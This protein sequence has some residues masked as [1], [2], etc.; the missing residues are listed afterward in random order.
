MKRATAI[1]V[2]VL[3]TAALPAAQ[4]ARVRDC[5]SIITYTFS[6]A[7]TLT[8]QTGSVEIYGP[9]VCVVQDS[10]GNV[11]SMEYTSGSA[12]LYAGTCGEVVMT[13]A[14]GYVGTMTAER[15]TLTAAANSNT[16]SAYG[17][18]GIATG[19]NLPCSGASEVVTVMR[20]YAFE[21][22]TTG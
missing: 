16:F 10:Q 7:L 17:N 13:N 18:I 1:L 8:P 3:S 6:S 9:T 4:A 5:V 19:V 21:N 20:W 14:N 11:Y 12:M 15:A 22:L 2:A